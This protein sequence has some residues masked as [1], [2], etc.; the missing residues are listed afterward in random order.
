MQEDEDFLTRQIRAIGQGLGV[1]IS[2]KNGGPNQ[3][4]FPKKQAE[5]LPHQADLKKLIADHQYGEAAERLS[6]LEFAIPHE[7][8]F[9]LSLWFFTQLNQLSDDQL[10]Q[11]GYSK[12]L[13]LIHLQ[14]I[15]RQGQ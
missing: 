13:I 7:S 8:Y 5:Q 3:I 6:R 10:R 2:G 4:V 9:K 1:A 12:T 15:K 14:S 11:G